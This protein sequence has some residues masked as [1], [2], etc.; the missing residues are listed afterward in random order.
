MQ[1]R[2]ALT[3]AGLVAHTTLK[4]PLSESF[5]ASLVNHFCLLYIQKDDKNKFGFLTLHHNGLQYL[6][7]KPFL[8]GCQRRWAEPFQ[9]KKN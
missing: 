9:N 7:L 6:L 1:V 4:P 3:S 2:E 5:S 8:V